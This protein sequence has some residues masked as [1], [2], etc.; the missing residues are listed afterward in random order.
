MGSSLSAREGTGHTHSHTGARIGVHP[1]GLDP[2]TDREGSC[3]ETSCPSDGVQTGAGRTRV[4]PDEP[5]V[6]SSG[7]GGQGR[8]PAD[9]SWG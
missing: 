4:E 5:S 6:V 7:V 1:T 9:L 8:R 3:G 2:R